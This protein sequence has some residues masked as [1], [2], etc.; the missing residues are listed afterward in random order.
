MIE[1]GYTKCLHLSV[2]SSTPTQMLAFRSSRKQR[3]RSSQK[4]GA[5]REQTSFTSTKC[6][7]RMHRHYNAFTLLQKTSLLEAPQRH[8]ALEDPSAISSYSLIRY[9]GENASAANE[10]MATI[11]LSLFLRGQLSKIHSLA[12]GC[13]IY[14]KMEV[15][16]L[17]AIRFSKKGNVNGGLYQNGWP[18]A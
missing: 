14:Y 6:V 15:R 16:R 7:N 3:R 2:F 10:K 1:E 8:V 4:G 12:L 11:L 18:R 17:L 9:H 5:N 13:F